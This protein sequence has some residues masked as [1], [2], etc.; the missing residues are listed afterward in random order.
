MNEFVGKKLG[1]VLAFCVVGEETFKK[2]IMA[3]TER[4]GE[5]FVHEYIDRSQTYA[6]AIKNFAEQGGVVDVVNKKLEGTGAKLRNMRDMYI[7]DEWDN[8]TELLEW[9]GFFQGAAVV[10]FALVRGSADK[11]NMTDLSALAN[12]A[13]EF[14]YQILERAQSELESVG[15]MKA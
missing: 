2:G 6:Q 13:L 1:E 5:E 11:L 4:L 3:L 12:E 8:A 10:H 15:Q 14:H 7:G 9:S